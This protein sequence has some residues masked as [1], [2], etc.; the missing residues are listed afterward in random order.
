EVVYKDKA[1]GVVY[2][3]ATQQD[4]EKFVSTSSTTDVVN[5][6]EYVNL[7]LDSPYLEKGV[8]L[9]DSPGLNGVAVGHQEVT[10]NQIE[11]SH[12]CIFMFN[13]TQPGKRSDFEVLSQLT[14][15]FNTIIL[16]LNQ[17]DKIKKD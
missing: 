8:M 4:I 7:F 11:K 13:S 12:A 1:K 6:V 10:E 2:G 14:K 16:V 5:E 17:I 3:E 15:K 9:V